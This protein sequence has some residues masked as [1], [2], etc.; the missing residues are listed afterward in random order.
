MNKIETEKHQPSGETSTNFGVSEDRKTSWFAEEV[1]APK[2]MTLEE[3]QELD[4]VIQGIAESAT[5]TD[6]ISRQQTIDACIDLLEN[7]PPVVTTERK[8][9]WE[10]IINSIGEV[11]C[12]CSECKMP[13][14]QG[15]LSFCG[16]CGAKMCGNKKGKQYEKERTHRINLK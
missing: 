9:K 8:G 16:N 7:L 13:R 15:Y 14:Q 10:Y 3:W 1:I 2:E 6:C 12:V 11:V 4:K 5:I